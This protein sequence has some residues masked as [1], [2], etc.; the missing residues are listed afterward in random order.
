MLAILLY[1]NEDIIKTKQ[2]VRK[3]RAVGG[4]MAEIQAAN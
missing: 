3:L 1:S 4:K 2:A